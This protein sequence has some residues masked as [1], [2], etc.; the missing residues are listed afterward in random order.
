L[1][2]G[3][4]AHARLAG[5]VLRA[6]HRSCELTG[7]GFSVATVRTVGFETDLCLADAEHPATPEPGSII[8]GTVFLTALIDSPPL[9]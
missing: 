5:T 7:Q 2:P 1:Q 3:Q 6:S 4:T 9:G 8:A